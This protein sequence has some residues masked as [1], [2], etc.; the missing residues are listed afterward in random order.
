MK[1]SKNKFQ[2]FTAQLFIF[3]TIFWNN[4][5]DI[6]LHFCQIW[7][8]TSH[9]LSREFIVGSWELQLPKKL[10]SYVGPFSNNTNPP[11][12]EGCGQK[13]NISAKKRLEKN[14]VVWH[15]ESPWQEIDY[16][17]KPWCSRDINVHSS[18][19]TRQNS[20]DYQSGVDIAGHTG[21]S[22]VCW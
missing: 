6:S 3:S 13:E 2:L 15:L 20:N 17:V 8:D 10:V 5:S 9:H 22:L 1:P 7:D 14:F 19:Y 18:Q 4:R 21:F 16:W 11:W 12:V